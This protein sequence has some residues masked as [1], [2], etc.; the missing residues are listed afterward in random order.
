MDRLRAAW[1][2]LLPGAIGL[3]GDVVQHYSEPPRAYH[4][5]T[6]LRHVLDTIERLSAP[7]AGKRDVQL[8][9]W[10][11]DIIYDP[12]AR[13]N[14]ERSAAFAA[15]A[16]GPLG[17]SESTIRRVG[18]LILLTKTHAADAGD[19]EAAV[20]L[21]ADLAILGAPAPDYLAYARAIRSEYAWVPEDA[22]RSGR[23][24]V[25]EQFLQRPRLFHNPLLFAEREA[26]ARRNLQDEIA[27]L[28]LGMPGAAD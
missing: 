16:L 6:H 17:V 5:L 4:N 1:T 18:D 9:A 14:E 11:H 23:G 7:Q 22:Y 25:L 24:A 20:L 3:F 28:K 2:M 26:A 13:D 15:A 27:M 8:A 12:R 21:D 10:F 19:H